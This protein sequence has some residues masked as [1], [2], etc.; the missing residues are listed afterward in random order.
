MLR[1]LGLLLLNVVHL[2][3]LLLLR[4]WLLDLLQLLLNLLLLLDGVVGRRR[5]QLLLEQR[6]TGQLLLISCRGSCQLL[7]SCRASCQL[8]VQQRGPL[9]LQLL[10]VDLLQGMVSIKF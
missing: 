3:D 1:Q 2:N 8:L 6:R 4:H 7:V 9:L 5:H 10:L